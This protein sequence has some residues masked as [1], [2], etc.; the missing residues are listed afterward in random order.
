MR[1]HKAVMDERKLDILASRLLTDFPYLS[2]EHRNP[3]NV[4]ARLIA[5]FSGVEQYGFHEVFEYDDFSGV[6]IFKDIVP[7]F[8]CELFWIVADESDYGRD[9]AR[10]F[11]KV[12]QLMVKKHG[13]RRVEAGT[14]DPKVRRLLE[15]MGFTCEGVRKD[16]FMYDGKTYDFNLMVWEDKAQ[17]G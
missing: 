11:E 3:Y 4:W 16:S 5:W 6:I 2:D 9:L 10:E 8:K 1:F 14:A 7:G 13:L 15:R 12:I 17:G